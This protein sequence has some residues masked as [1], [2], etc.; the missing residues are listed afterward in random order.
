MNSFTLLLLTFKDT[1]DYLDLRSYFVAKEQLNLRKRHFEE[2][3]TP[4][5]RLKLVQLRPPA[6]H[7]TSNPAAINP[8]KGDPVTSSGPKVD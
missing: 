1:E 4:S 6:V 8:G 5:H 2:K 7:A 3:S